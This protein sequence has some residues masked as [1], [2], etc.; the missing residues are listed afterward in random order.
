MQYSDQ[1][2]SLLLDYRTELL[3]VVTEAIEAV[4]EYTGEITYELTPTLWELLRSTDVDLDL[5]EVADQ[6]Y[7]PEAT[8]I[9]LCGRLGLT[10]LKVDLLSRI[11]PAED[12]LPWT[13]MLKVALERLEGLESDIIDYLYRHTTIVANLLE[14]HGVTDLDGYYYQTY[15]GYG[16]LSNRALAVKIIYEHYLAE[17]DELTRRS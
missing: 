12:V 4:D 13:V 10:P 3:A 11:S 14:E 8:M 15:A 9:E 1:G 6:E 16:A 17:L 5:A 7:V 2:L